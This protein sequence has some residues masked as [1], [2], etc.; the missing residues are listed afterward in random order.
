M[1]KIRHQLG[2]T[3]EIKTY[4]IKK[5]FNKD[6]MKTTQCQSLSTQKM[7]MIMT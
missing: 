2:T 7:F 6:F 1:I 5:E 3:F 4:A